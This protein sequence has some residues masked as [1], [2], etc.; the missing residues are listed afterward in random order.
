MMAQLQGR[1]WVNER[2]LEFVFPCLR[3]GKKFES[4]NKLPQEIF[5][6][7]AVDDPDT[8]ALNP[9]DVKAF[10]DQKESGSGEG[11]Y[12]DCQY[13]AFGAHAILSN[14]VDLDKEPDT[15]ERCL[16][17]ETVDPQHF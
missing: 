3:R 14:N 11:R 5:E 6:M 8:R 10:G 4:F 15:S 7:L 13:C 12:N 16:I 17:S 1:Y 2:S 9:E